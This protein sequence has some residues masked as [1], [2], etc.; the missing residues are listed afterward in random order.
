MIEWK[1]TINPI[2]KWFQYATTVP[3]NHKEIGKDSGK[4]TKIKPFINK[5]NRKGINYP[6]EKHKWKKFG[7]HNL[8]IAPNVL[9]AK[10]EK[11]YPTYVSKHNSKREKQFILLMIPKKERWH[12]IAVKRLSAL[13][14]GITSKNN[15]NFY[16]LNCFHLFRTKNKLEPHRKVCEN[17]D[18]CR[19]VMSYEET[20]I[21]QLS[22]PEI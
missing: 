9:Y 3:L 15:G 14:T 7:K 13:L 20:K 1:A 11:I 21:L 18:F 19:V 2:N 8:T 10:N 17:K 22:I 12:Y 5:H 6:S 16:C 4:I